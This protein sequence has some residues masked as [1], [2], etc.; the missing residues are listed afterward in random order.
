MMRLEKFE[1]ILGLYLFFSP[2]QASIGFFVRVGDI[3][4]KNLNP[5]LKFDI[6]FQAILHRRATKRKGPDC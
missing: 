1:Q 3:I 2:G 5:D 4:E 6:L